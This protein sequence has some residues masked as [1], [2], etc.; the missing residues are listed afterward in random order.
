MLGVRIPNMHIN[1]MDSEP[2]KAIA[3]ERVV[4]NKLHLWQKSKNIKKYIFDSDLFLYT[5]NL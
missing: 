4:Q 5:R 2:A 1:Q 3:S